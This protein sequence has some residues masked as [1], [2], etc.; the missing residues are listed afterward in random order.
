MEIKDEEIRSLLRANAESPSF[1][2]ASK[3]LRLIQ[4]KQATLISRKELVL[5]RW[6]IGM[7]L[8]FLSICLLFSFKLELKF[9]DLNWQIPSGSLHLHWLV[10]LASLF[11]A[12]GLWIFILIDRKY[13]S[14]DHLG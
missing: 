6:I 11:L 2:F 10:L 14:T 8:T 4:A 3:T 12:A 9:S 1:G 5:N 13:N 7:V